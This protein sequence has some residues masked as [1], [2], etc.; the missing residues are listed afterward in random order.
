MLQARLSVGVQVQGLLG[1]GVAA[2]V[3]V[4]VGNVGSAPT[5]KLSTTV[6]LPAGVLVIAM[7]GAG[8]GW[9]CAAA[10]SGTTQCTHQK[11]AAGATA[12]ASFSV[13]VVSLAGCGNGVLATATSGSLS[14]RGQSS[15]QVQCLL[16]ML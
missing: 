16:G 5:G 13:L 10:A 7:P 14:A 15:T 3:G 12:S 4:R 9:T 2:T 1:L 8:S 11:L 6:T